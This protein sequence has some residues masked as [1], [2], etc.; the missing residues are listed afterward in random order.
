MCVYSF[1]MHADWLLPQFRFGNKGESEEGVPVIKMRLD[2]KL[3]S[4]LVYVILNSF[5]VYVIRIYVRNI[6]LTVPG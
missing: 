6:V 5:L 3:N 2:R 4:F 1:A